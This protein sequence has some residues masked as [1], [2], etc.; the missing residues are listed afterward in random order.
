MGVDEKMKS[1][2]IDKIGK[3][4][5]EVL[6]HFDNFHLPKKIIYLG[7]ERNRTWLDFERELQ[8]EEEQ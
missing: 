7:D 6:K 5:P 1:H 3:A 2:E 4:K 8:E